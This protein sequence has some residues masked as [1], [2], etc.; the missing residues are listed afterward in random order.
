MF[1][2]V[3]GLQKA[4]AYQGPETVAELLQRVGGLTPAGDPNEV[5]V[6]RANVAEGTR[7]EVLA[8][9]LHDI[10]LKKDMKTNIP[11]EPC[12]EIYIGEN[13]QATFAKGVPPCIRPIYDKLCSWFRQMATKQPS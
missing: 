1:G 10:L 11:L 12:D 6:I 4:V 5:F 3:S 2:K 8:V 9:N 13:R 7:P